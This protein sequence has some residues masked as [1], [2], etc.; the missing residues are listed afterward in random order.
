MDRPLD[1]T[2]DAAGNGYIADTE[3]ETIWKVNA[4]G[5]ISRFAGTSSSGY[6]GDG[7]LAVN[8]QIDAPRGITVDSI[9]NLYFTDRDRHVVRVVSSHNS[10]IYTLAGTGTAG[11]NG[12]DM[13]AVSTKLNDPAGIEILTS[14]SNKT[15]YTCD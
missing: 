4:S 5:Q 3:N 10:F 6:S 14:Q 13:P 12:M 1:F 15:I 2:I 8:A 9:G 11:Y 7:G